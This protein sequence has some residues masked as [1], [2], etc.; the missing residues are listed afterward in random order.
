MIMKS[1]SIQDYILKT[2]R[3]LGVAAAVGEAWPAAREELV[4]GFL[5]RLE[6]RLK[7]KLKGWHFE[8]AD[9][10]YVD[11]YA[12]YFFW[13]Q[14][15][16]HQYGLGLQWESY[17]EQVFF[18]VFREKDDIGQ[19]RFSEELLNAVKEVQP[20]TKRNTWWEAKVQINSPAT[21]WRKPVVLWQMHTDKKFLDEVA[22]QLLELAKVSEP[23]VDK[24]VRKYKK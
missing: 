23:I 21:D 22:L 11:A 10:I 15:W 24:L 13:K 6:S 8:P 2:E 16:V 3:N 1:D 5:A 19:R 17:G 20:Q 4:A 7:R 14:S 12:G 9:R 18:G